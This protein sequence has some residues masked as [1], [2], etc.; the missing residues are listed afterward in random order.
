M[1]A[2][3]RAAPPLK[4]AATPSVRSKNGECCPAVESCVI[5]SGGAIDWPLGELGAPMAT[6]SLDGKASRDLSLKVCDPPQATAA[7]SESVKR[8]RIWFT[9]VWGET[10]GP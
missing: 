6:A 10:P 2:S 1:I 9:P 8:L 4:V 5:W 7:A 3:I